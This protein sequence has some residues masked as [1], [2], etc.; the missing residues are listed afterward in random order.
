MYIV[1]N[2]FERYFAYVEPKAQEVR[3]R[4]ELESIETYGHS[5]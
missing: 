2:F 3:N 5:F 4:V 1:T